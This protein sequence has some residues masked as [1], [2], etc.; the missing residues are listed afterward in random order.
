[1]PARRATPRMT[2]ASARRLS[3]SSTGGVKA[4][5]GISRGVRHR[6]TVRRVLG[7]G[8]QRRPLWLLYKRSPLCDG[9]LDCALV[10]VVRRHEGT[11]DNF[12]LTCVSQPRMFRRFSV[13]LSV[14][15]R[16]C[17]RQ[18]ASAITPAARRHNLN[19]PSGSIRD[20]QS[21]RITDDMHT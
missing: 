15:G 13:L 4:R 2:P 11:K 14:V 20:I 3:C 12:P 7:C 16:P 21:A 9:R 10:Q 6:L 18:S 8:R 17:L 5:F 19:G 1:L